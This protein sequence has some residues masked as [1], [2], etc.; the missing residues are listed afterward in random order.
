[1]TIDTEKD[2]SLRRILVTLPAGVTKDTLQQIIDNLE[3]KTTLLRRW[4]IC[5]TH[6]D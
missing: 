5:K 1:M 4:K 2:K 6:R 3:R